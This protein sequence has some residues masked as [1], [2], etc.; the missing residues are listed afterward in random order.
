M[1]AAGHSRRSRPHP[2]L[3]QLDGNLPANGPHGRSGPPQRSQRSGNGAARYGTAGADGS[4]PRPDRQGRNDAPNRRRLSAGGTA[5]PVRGS[6][7]CGRQSRRGDAGSRIL[8]QPSRSAAG[9][10]ARPGAAAA[11]RPGDRISGLHPEGKSSREGRTQPAD[12]AA[13]ARSAGLLRHRQRPAAVPAN[14]PK[15]GRAAARPFHGRRSP[16]VEPDR[17]QASGR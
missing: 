14:D 5:N 16:V 2:R 7:G 8:R 12:R 1:P 9:G 17:S 10:T 6:G 15:A 13:R 3:H 4:E 11:G